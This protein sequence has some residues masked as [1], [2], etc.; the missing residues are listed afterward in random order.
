MV[1]PLQY[2]AIDDG[3]AEDRGSVE[4]FLLRCLI[5]ARDESN[6]PSNHTGFDEDVNVYVVGLLGRFLSAEYHDEARRYCYPTDLDLA[7]EIEAQDDE[8]FCYRAYRT[9]ADQLFLGVGLFSHVEGH[10]V[11]TDPVF[12]RSPEE[13]SGRGSTYYNLASSSLRRLRRRS[14][15]PELAMNKLA[16]RFDEYTAILKRVRTSY[17]HL[18]CHI[19]DGALF[20]LAR[21]EETSEGRAELWDRFLD[22]WSEWKRT[23]EDDALARLCDATELLHQIDPSFSFELPDA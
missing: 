8:R 16:A 13:L 19:S 5:G 14:T 1:P 15:G 9:N 23:G 18:T 4:E 10:G 20:H 17:F 12:G 2:T 6:L 21:P 7:R 22:A 3:H 11:S